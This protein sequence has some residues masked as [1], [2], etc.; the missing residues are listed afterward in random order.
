MPTIRVDEEVWNELQKKAEP[1]VD[2]PN[3]VLRRVLGLAD[4]RKGAQV[5]SGLSS[6]TG[7][8]RSRRRRA[9]LGLRREEY[10]QPIL[11]ALVTMGGE[12]HRAEVLAFV[13]DRVES[14]LT[15]DDRQAVPSGTEIRWRKNAG[16]ERYDMTKS[17]LL[18]Q[19][20]PKGIWRLTDT[21]WRASGKKSS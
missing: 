15:P 6:S 18:D 1:L 17:G 10:R 8:T 21:G 16:F 3:S 19:A 7:A 2:N 4:H 5:R 14:R 13:H 9:V 11:D 12:A 20:A